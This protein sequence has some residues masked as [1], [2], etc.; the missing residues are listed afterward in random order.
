MDVQFKDLISLN[1]SND[2]EPENGF[3]TA[4]APPRTTPFCLTTTR[5][6]AMM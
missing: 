2:A 1:F 3:T 6:E 4:E 5:A